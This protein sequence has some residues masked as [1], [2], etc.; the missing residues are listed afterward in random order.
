MLSLVPYNASQVTSKQRSRK[1]KPR[2]SN[3]R[4][5]PNQLV[6][7]GPARL[8]QSMQQDDLMTTQINNVGQVASSGTGVINTVFDAYLQASTPADWT[9]FASLYTEFRILSM[10]VELI[11][12]NKYN[13][14][15]TNVLA[16]LYSVTDRASGS[17]I[18][19]LAAAVDYESA[20]AHEPSTHAKRVIK[21]ASVEEAQWI[22]TGA[23]PAST[24]RLYVKLFSAGNSNSL[25]LYDFVSRMVVQ[26]RGRQ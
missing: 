13:Q 11:P 12:W 3:F 25:T 2:K 23:T 15:T 19:S 24:A 26:F 7:N 17:T 18:G 8:P 5:G 9:S 21:M 16:P 20:Q 6:Y 1:G 14:P 10:E 22:Q 4:P